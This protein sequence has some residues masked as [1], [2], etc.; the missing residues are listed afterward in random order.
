[1]PQQETRPLPSGN[2]I[3]A[4]AAPRTTP[5]PRGAIGRCRVCATI[6]PL[7]WPADNE[8]PGNW[9]CA[10]CGQAYRGVWI[11]NLPREFA[12]NAR[13]AD[14]R[15]GE[16]PD[17]DPDPDVEAFLNP[18]R[19]GQ[20]QSHPITIAFPDRPRIVCDLENAFSGRLDDAL[21]RPGALVLPPQQMP[22]T[23]QICQTGGRG[24]DAACI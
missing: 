15:G 2:E 21:R 12:K 23:A 10:T 1:M 8:T 6:L 4:D 3:L 13:P 5:T 14:R 22:L 11:Q 7:R 9:V 19:A 18:L 20:G 17:G 24:Y 16:P